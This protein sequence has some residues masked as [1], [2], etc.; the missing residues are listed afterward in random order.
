MNKET[1]NLTIKEEYVLIN[2]SKLKEDF[3]E[4]CDG[5]CLSY[6]KEK[7]FYELESFNRLLLD[8]I[9]KDSITHYRPWNR[10]YG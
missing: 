8:Y 9:I 2:I 5:L 3:K 6:E 1:K 10:K 4:A 7:R